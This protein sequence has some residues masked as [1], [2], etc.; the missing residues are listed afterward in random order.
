MPTLQ[1]IS[2]CTFLCTN[3]LALWCLHVSITSCESMKWYD[4]IYFYVWGI[5]ASHVGNS[6][7]ILDFV[8]TCLSCNM[9]AWGIFSF[10]LLCPY[11][12]WVVVGG[13]LFVKAQLYGAQE[14]MATES[15]F[16][17]EVVWATSLMSLPSSNKLLFS[18]SCDSLML[19]KVIMCYQT[20]CPLQ[21]GIMWCRVT[22]KRKSTYTKWKALVKCITHARLNTIMVVVLWHVYT[23]T[24][25]FAW[26]N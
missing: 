14:R 18:Y 16:E 5:F 22:V 2:I 7:Y 13:T 6:S 19:V 9:Y 24:C 10:M 25:I 11:V 8:T 23:C 12:L 1:R 20:I 26:L 15:K 3:G 17:E 4:V 21:W